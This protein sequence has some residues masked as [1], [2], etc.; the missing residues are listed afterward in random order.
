VPEVN[1]LNRAK[2][3][4]TTERVVAPIAPAWPFGPGS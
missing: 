4:P 2:A 3:I 1:L